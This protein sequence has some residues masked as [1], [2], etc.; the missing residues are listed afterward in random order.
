MTTAWPEVA[1][2]EVASIVMGQAP[3]GD[4]YNDR[5]EGWPLI[6]GAGDFGIG[7][8]DAK[9]Y[10]SSPKKLCARG[11]IV[12]G[13]RA[14]IGARVLADREYCLGRGVAGLRG[15]DKLHDRYLWHWLTD[16]AGRLAGKG[17]GA[18]FLQVNHADI[19]EMQLPLPPIEEQRRIAAVLDQ[20]DA[21]RAKR[22]ESVALAESLASSF[23]DAIFGPPVSNPRGWP[24]RTLS[25]V[26]KEI[27][28]GPFGSL[29]HQHDYVEG[30][31]PLVN[32][33][34]IVGSSIEPDPRHSV[35]P[36]KAT[37]LARYRLRAGD[38]VMGRRGEM[39]RCALVTEASEGFLCGSGSL[40]I[41]PDQSQVLALY[42]HHAL[43]SPEMRAH[44]E[45]KALGVTMMNL[46]SSIVGA[47]PMPTPPICEQQRFAVAADASAALPVR[48]SSAGET[49]DAL[50]GS[51]QQRAFSGV[52]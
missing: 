34:H 15:L 14:S 16:S 27:Q 39:G 4:T 12:L 23:F 46:N 30:G 40:F 48:L 32:P 2:G 41:R 26:S 9:K 52:L 11:D 6:A 50:F 42:V 28:I 21:V 20:A 13:I 5:G 47:L 7:V 3:A 43:T 49:L 29:L 33:M 44:L 38:I 10:T 8:P 17:R 31:V 24:A 18:T 35:N 19:A 36:Q 37:A 45:R 51:L 22:R 25:D 1:L